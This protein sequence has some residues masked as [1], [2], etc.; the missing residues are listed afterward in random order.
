[1]IQKDI[2]IKQQVSFTPKKKGLPTWSMAQGIKQ[3]R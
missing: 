3:R 2:Q 1:M